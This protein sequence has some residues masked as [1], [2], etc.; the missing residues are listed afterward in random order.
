MISVGPEAVIKWTPGKVSL[1]IIVITL[2][3]KKVHALQS[4]DVHFLRCVYFIRKE[5]GVFRN[6]CSCFIG[7]F[8][9]SE[10][11]ANFRNYH[12]QAGDSSS[13]TSWTFI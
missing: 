11:I 1:H 12:F 13:L 9:S 7:M 2:I 6:C 3:I 10:Q 5:I 4:A 8:I